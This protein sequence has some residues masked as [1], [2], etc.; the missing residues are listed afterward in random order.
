MSRIYGID[1]GTTNSLIGRGE[2]LNSGLVTSIVNFTTERAGSTYRDSIEEC[3]VRS[4]KKDMSMGQ[5]GRIAIK[6]S[7]VVLSELKKCVTDDIVEDVIITVPAYFTDNNRNATKE[8]AKKAGLNVH[9]LINEPTAAAMY[10][11]KGKKTLT[12]VYDL[13]GGTFDISLVDN[14]LGEYFVKT[15]DG[16]KIG[17]DNLDTELRKVIMRESG[18]VA[19]RLRDGDD[20]KLKLIAE[21][22]K[23]KLQKQRKDVLLDLSQFAYA[24]ANSEYTLTEETY[25]VIMR[26][27]FATTLKKT[28]R[29][30]Q[31]PS[32]LP[33]GEDFNFLLVGGS[34]RDPYL[35]EWLTEEVGKAPEELT[36]DPDRIV[37]QG[38]AYCAELEESGQLDLMLTDIISS[39]IGLELINGTMKFVI[40]KDA[41]L[42]IKESC[43]VVNQGEVSKLVLNLRQ[44]DSKLAYNNELL[45]SMTFDYGQAVEPNKG[46]LTVSVSV[47]NSGLI[48]LEAKWGRRK[49]QKL[50]LD[51]QAYIERTEA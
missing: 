4:F 26:K 21:D 48:S 8:A 6:A 31:N 11:N 40:P 46:L 42:P 25:K 33:L 32:Y 34:T 5:E 49:K 35:R 39:P 16:N 2:N 14:R 27:T 36:Y 17:G 44:G 10:Y 12:L 37:A 22:A 18:I 45:G 41:R 7:A 28:L 9:R 23:I 38:A 51:R 24:G 1:L 29:I 30:V 47:D 19:H 50:V 43:P 13:G 20:L 15:T 3:V